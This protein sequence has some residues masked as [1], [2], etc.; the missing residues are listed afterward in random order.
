MVEHMLHYAPVEQAG[1]LRAHQAVLLIAAEKEALMDN[2]DHSEKVYARLAG[3]KQYVVI[4]DIGHFEIYTKAFDRATR[5]ATDWF[6]KYL[7]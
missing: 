1:L 4:P 2:R 3:P 5:L 7:K 6:G